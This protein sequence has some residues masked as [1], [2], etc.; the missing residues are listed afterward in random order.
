MIQWIENKENPA[1]FCAQVGVCS[2]IKVDRLRR[3]P[4]V[5]QLPRR[6]R[7][8][9]REVVEETQ[10]AVCQICQLV[11]TYVEQLVAQNNTIAA[12]EAEVDQMCAVLPS[13]LNSA[14]C[15]FSLLAIYGF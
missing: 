3:N 2:S 11:I 4:A 14:V 15:S 12:I 5:N 6:Q 9:K 10:G 8:A 13:P 1:T 7:Q